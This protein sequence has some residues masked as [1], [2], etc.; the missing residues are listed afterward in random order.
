MFH[1]SFAAFPWEVLEV[2]AF[3]DLANPAWPQVDNPDTVVFTWRHWGNFTGEYKGNK[4]KG[5]LVEMYG[6]ASAKISRTG[7]IVGLETIS[8]GKPAP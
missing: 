1:K 3:P 5:E 6:F 8:D 7:P 2:I 4:G